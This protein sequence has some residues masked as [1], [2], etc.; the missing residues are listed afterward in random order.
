M[1]TPPPRPPRRRR[2]R[3]LSDSD[4]DAV[5]ADTASQ[6]GPGELSPPPR[7]SSARLR[8]AATP[9]RRLPRS[10]AKSND[11]EDDEDDAPS[12]P[13][14]SVRRPRAAV[15]RCACVAP[16]YAPGTP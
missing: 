12:S 16:A 6:R 7:R 11:D 4:V 2:R 5:D 1:A 14:P 3:Y 8:E 15:P 10:P 13:S 9:R